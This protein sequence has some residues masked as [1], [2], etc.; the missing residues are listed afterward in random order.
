M[1][2][3]AEELAMMYADQEL[4]AA[5]ARGVEEHLPGCPACRDLVATLRAENAAL[6][7]YFQTPAPNRRLL[8]LGRLTG[9]VAASATLA[10]PLQWMFT[11]VAEAGVWLN[12]VVNVPFEVAFRAVRAFAPLVLLLILAQAVSPAMT[13][14]TGEGAV[15]IPSQETIQDS[16]FASGET[17]TV[18]GK[19]EGNLFVFGRSVEVR[20]EVVGDV[21]AGAQAVRITGSVTGNVVAG[22]ETILIRGHVGGNLYSGGRNVHIEKEGRVDL[23]AFTGSETVTVDGLLGRGLTSGASTA[24]IAGEVMRGI[25]FGGD[26]LLIRSTGKVGGDIAAQVPNR[27]NV[28]VDPGASV[29]GKLDIG[30]SEARRASNRWTSPGTYIWQ[31]V[32][33]AGAF[34][35]GWLLMSV[36]P[37][38][39]AATIQHIRSWTTVAWGVVAVIVTPV[40]AV[41]LC[42]TLIGLPLG[43]G[44]IFA[45]AA[46]LYLAKIFVAA[47]LGREIVGARGDTGLPTLPGLLAGLIIL[48]VLSLIPY[49]G[50]ILGF[51]I[52]CVGLGAPLLRLRQQ[53]A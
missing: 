3:L 5:E 30:T 25:T 2:C 6:I 20:G 42:I 9:A 27:A 13:R 38:F 19:I 7:S 41:L 17:V 52:V 35:A 33:L 49:V 45:Y 39:F 10:V 48:Q 18:E 26:R 12:Y 51:A 37:G 36:F 23:D 43:I 50:A 29:G 40:L 21:F 31:V 4:N 22:A 15:V 16:V 8:A 34:G 24:V 11:R 53:L 1:K 46:G 28:Q 47:Y 14:R 32:V 44:A